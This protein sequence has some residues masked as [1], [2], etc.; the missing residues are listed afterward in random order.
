[1]EVD[2]ASFGPAPR[3]EPKSYPGVRPD[4]SYLFTGTHIIPFRFD[5]LSVSLANFGIDTD[6]VFA[7]IGYGSNASPAQLASKFGD[8]KCVMP[9]IR[10]SIGGFDAVY[11][12]GLAA[13]GYVPATLAESA[14][15]D[16]E[17]WANVLTQKQ[18]DVMNRSEGR[19]TYYH[20]TELPAKFNIENGQKI[21][22]A[23]AY[24]HA[25]GPLMAGGEPI[26]LA[27]TTA[28]GRTFGAASQ[29]DAMDLVRSMIA[30]SCESVDGFIDLVKRDVGHMRRLLEK[31]ESHVLKIPP[32]KESEPILPLSRTCV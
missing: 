28:S 12:R 22:A 7:V 32:I 6:E 20:L 17:A 27:E 31:F 18:M 2:T 16:V 1:M 11:A 4:F 9:V 13:Y 19:G 25:D 3:D 30:E 14:G 23:Y 8:G 21:V 15:T 26:A 29:V 24:V 10:G 5:D